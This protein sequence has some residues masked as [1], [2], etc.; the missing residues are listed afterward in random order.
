M[1]LHCQ[2]EAAAL[3]AS[4]GQPAGRGRFED[5]DVDDRDV[6]QCVLLCV[7][8]RWH[9]CGGGGG[10]GGGDSLC[11]EVVRQLFICTCLLKSP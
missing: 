9:V 10:G 11:V 4:Q 5:G 6:Y 2:W 8:S 1:L 3:H 7:S